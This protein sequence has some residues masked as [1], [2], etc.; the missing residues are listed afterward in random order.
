[1]AA[2]TGYSIVHKI[3]G[4]TTL[5]FNLQDGSFAALTNLSVAEAGYLVD[6]LRNEKPVNFDPALKLVGFGTSEPV[7]EGE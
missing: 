3:G 1:M 5:Q 4:R 7:G 2:I 6:L